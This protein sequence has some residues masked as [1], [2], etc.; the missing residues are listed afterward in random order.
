MRIL[1]AL[2]GS[3]S[4]VAALELIQS[5]PWPAGTFIRVLGAYHVPIDWTGGFGDSA[6][7]RPPSA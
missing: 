1:L 5:L 4:S 6:G 3:P 2:D 7:G